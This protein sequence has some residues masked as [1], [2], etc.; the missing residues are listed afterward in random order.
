MY[1]KNSGEQI[2]VKAKIGE[3]MQFEIISV[4]DIV[5]IIKEYGN[6]IC[7]VNNDPLTW[8]RTPRYCILIRLN[9]PEPVSPFQIN[10]KGFG[11]ASAWVSV[12]SIGNIT[13]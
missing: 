11:M 5:A 7:L 1:F 9:N 13:L 10:K 6:D 2:T 4:Q 3:V 8:G 12:E